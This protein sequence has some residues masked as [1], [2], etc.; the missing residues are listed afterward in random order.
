M[1]LLQ[2]GEGIVGNVDP[3]LPVSWWAALDFK[4]YK[5]TIRPQ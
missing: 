1:H 5:F 4:C 2:W 3:I